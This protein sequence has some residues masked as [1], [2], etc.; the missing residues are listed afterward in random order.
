MART[1]VDTNDQIT[2]LRVDVR[3]LAI[4]GVDP[5]AMTCMTPT[6]VRPGLV[7]RAIAH[8][9]IRRA[10]RSVLQLLHTQAVTTIANTQRVRSVRLVGIHRQILYWLLPTLVQVVGP[11]AA[12]HVRHQAV[13]MRLPITAIRATTIALVAIRSAA[14]LASRATRPPIMLALAPTT[15][16]LAEVHSAVRLASRATRL[17]ITLVQAVT[18]LAPVVA[19]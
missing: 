2:P 9:P 6:V 13:A 17:H 11:S 4:P 12:R 16:A 14:R 10:Q 1:G 3:V 5:T 8:L 19:Q 15:T 18:T 7:L